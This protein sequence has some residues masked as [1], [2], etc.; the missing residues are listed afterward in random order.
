MVRKAFD[1]SEPYLLDALPVPDF[2]ANDI[3]SISKIQLLHFLQ[4]EPPQTPQ[5]P[6]GSSLLSDTIKPDTSPL[7]LPLHVQ[8]YGACR[9]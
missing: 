6:V 3:F 9:L 7:L 1:N 5:S 8:A 2:L 4:P